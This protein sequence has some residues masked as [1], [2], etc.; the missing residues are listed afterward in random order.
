M[1]RRRD[2]VWARVTAAVLVL[3]VASSMQAKE[4]PLERKVMFGLDRLEV[5]WFGVPIFMMLE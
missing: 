2:S 4:N 1:L 5:S 3:W